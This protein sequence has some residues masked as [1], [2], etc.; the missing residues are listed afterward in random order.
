MGHRLTQHGVEVD[1]VKTQAITDMPSP[2]D[3]Q[4]V[5]RLCRMVQYLA[6]FLPNL[7]DDLGPL[8]AL[9]HQDTPWEWN[10]ACEEAFS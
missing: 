4:G 8:R 7:S 10:Q 2:V 5:C 9:T 6:R 3:V 1:P